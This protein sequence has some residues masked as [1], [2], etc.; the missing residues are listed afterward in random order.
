MKTDSLSAFR[1]FE[2]AGWERP[3]KA[4]AYDATWGRITSRAIDSLLDAAGV[5]PGRRV[6]DLATGPGYAAAKAEERGAT[7]VGVDIAAQM[8]AMA[9]ALHPGIEFRQA[10]AEALPFPDES[11]DAVVGNFIV[12][13]LAR[14][15]RAVDETRRVLRPGGRV[16]LTVWDR[17]EQAV[18][19]GLVLDAIQA[20]GASPPGD[21]PAGPPQFQF[22]D[23]E[24]F[25]RLLAEAGLGDVVVRRLAFNH[26]FHGTDELWSCI[27]DGSVRLRSLVVSQWPEV[28]AAIRTELEQRA[29]AYQHGGHLDLP[30]S[31]KLAAAAK[32]LPR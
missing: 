26:R 29:A 11:F 15:G 23:D 7:A 21:L 24:A 16:A 20:A 22:A 19:I 27:V 13:H 1:A 2:V 25:G 8:V 4:E 31:I 9:A 28:Q 3:G 14:P 30:V 17:P 5:R 6:L 10:D 18:F 32:P 12:L